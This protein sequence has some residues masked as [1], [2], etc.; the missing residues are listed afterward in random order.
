MFSSAERSGVSQLPRLSTD[1]PH[2]LHI[3]SRI[4]FM[5]YQ[6]VLRC[7]GFIYLAHRVQFVHAVLMS[8]SH[9]VVL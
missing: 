4:S 6:F 2:V 9:R 7:L 8:D 3:W 1:L 5:S